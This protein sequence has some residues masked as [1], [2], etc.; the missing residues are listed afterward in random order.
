[1]FTSPLT[2]NQGVVVSSAGDW[3]FTEVAQILSIMA[4]T[5]GK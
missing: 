1:M 4:V 3:A 2:R 5:L